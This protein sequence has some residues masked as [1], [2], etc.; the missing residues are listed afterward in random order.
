MNKL[1]VAPY[2]EKY[3]PE[4]W[5]KTYS[6]PVN[7]CATFGKVDED[8]GIL[9]NFGRTPI[10]IKDVTFKNV[11]QLFQMAKFRE[12][13][14]LKE[15]YEAGGGQGVKM[16]Q[17]KYTPIPE[18][19]EYFI[20]FLKFCLVQKYEQSEDFRKELE[21]SKGLYIVE[22][23]ASKKKQCEAYCMQLKDDN[24]VGYNL[25]G[26]LLMEL[27]DKGTLEYHL[28]DNAL[29]FVDILKEEL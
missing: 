18:W 17:K 14:I 1:S 26:Q 24:Y 11:E 19:G 21:R 20:D 13:E 27:R 10:K 3:Y 8:W 16:K 23:Q 25:M 12:K 4:Y 28:P 7:Q 29:D 22:K 9:G 15:L 6:Y 2:I 5:G